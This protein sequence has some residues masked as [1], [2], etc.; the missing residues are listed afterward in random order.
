MFLVADKT[1]LDLFVIYQC[2]RNYHKTY[3][4]QMTA[5]L[6]HSFC[7]SGSQRW[8]SWVSHRLQSRWW[9]GQLSSQGSNGGRVRFSA[10]L[11]WMLA[12]FTSW[13][14]L[15]AMWGPPQSR[16]T[17]ATCFIRT[18][19]KSQREYNQNGSQSFITQ[20]QRWRPITFA[21]LCSLKASHQV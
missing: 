9:P 16:A 11:T 6:S 7:G 15:L 5:F 21:I 10:P 2:V 12:G 18:S 4:P 19:K 20:F 1:L 3:W 13:L 14:A 8:L 17:T